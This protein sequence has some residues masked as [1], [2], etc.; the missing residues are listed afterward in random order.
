[1]QN[2]TQVG[3]SIMHFF[4]MVKT[5]F[6]TKITMIRSDNGTEFFNTPCL[7]FLSKTGVLHQ[8]FIVGSPQQNGI[9]ETSLRH[10]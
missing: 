6:N 4:N 1:L 10:C 9:A 7:A 8:K 3:P 2:K 5:Q